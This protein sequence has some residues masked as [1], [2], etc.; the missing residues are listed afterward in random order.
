MELVTLT[1]LGQVLSNAK[2]A[3]DAIGRAVERGL[4]KSGKLLL[5]ESQRLVPVDTGNLKASG[6]V[7]SEGAGARTDVTVG[8]TANYAVYVHEDLE[9][10]HGSEYNVKHLLLYK[11]GKK[12]GQMV[13]QRGPDQQAKFLEKPAHEL[14]PVI[15]DLLVNEIKGVKN[16]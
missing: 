2:G 9:K 11:H 7:R 4:K 5:R 16:V 13:V 12:K 3:S 8:Y 14:R 10:A 6:F 15:I 1:G